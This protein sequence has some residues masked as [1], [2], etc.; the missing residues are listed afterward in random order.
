MSSVFTTKKEAPEGHLAHRVPFA[1]AESSGGFS[2][3]NV[4]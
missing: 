4:G 3:S 2:W 1:V